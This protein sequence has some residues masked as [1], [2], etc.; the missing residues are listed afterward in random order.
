MV[1]SRPPSFPGGLFVRLVVVRQYMHG[2]GV[3]LK[4]RKGYM[5]KSRYIPVFRWGSISLVVV[6]GKNEG[7]GSGGKGYI[8]FPQSPLEF[9]SYLRVSSPL[10]V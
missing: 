10:S 2:Y 3:P 5:G 6:W 4:R 1:G 8:P 7:N 9:N